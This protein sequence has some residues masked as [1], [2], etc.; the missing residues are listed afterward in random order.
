MIF[1]KK[2]ERLKMSKKTPIIFNKRSP[3]TH[4]LTLLN[5]TITRL[6]KKKF[7]TVLVQNLINLRMTDLKKACGRK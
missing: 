7:K 6:M 1:T 5:K 4:D 2:H 3:G